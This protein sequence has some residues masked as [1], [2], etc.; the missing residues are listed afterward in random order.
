MAGVGTLVVI[1][2]VL[3]IWAGQGAVGLGLAAIGACLV[4]GALRSRP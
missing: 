4:Y 1:V 2:G 3:T